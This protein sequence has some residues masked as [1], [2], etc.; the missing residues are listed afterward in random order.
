MKPK[1]A[2]TPIHQTSTRRNL[3]F[4]AL[5]CGAIPANLIES[6][7]FG[8]ERGAFTTA[9]YQR[10]GKFEIA[11]GGTL[12]LDEIGELDRELQVIIQEA[13]RKLDSPGAVATETLFRVMYHH[14]RIR[15][16]RIG[17]EDHLAQLTRDD[18]WQYYRSRYVPRNTIV[19]IVGDI[20]PDEAL[21]MAEANSTPTRS[22]LR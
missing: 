9:M 21:A 6:E 4:V 2:G 15:R 8:H 16:W 19:A 20:D 14:H 3:P 22:R 12:F 18:V 11:H 10:K 13:K 17:H 5:N 7:L 1:S